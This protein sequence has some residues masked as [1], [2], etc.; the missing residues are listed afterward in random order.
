[1]TRYANMPQDDLYKAVRSLRASPVHEHF[2]EY[3]ER[4]R[5]AQT[6]RALSATDPVEIYRAQGQ[7]TAL[8]RILADLNLSS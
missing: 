5:G 3:L 4:M 8:N 1:M 2:I 7:V 6:Q